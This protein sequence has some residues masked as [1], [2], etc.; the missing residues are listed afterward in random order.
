MTQVYRLCCSAYRASPSENMLH[1]QLLIHVSSPSTTNNEGGGWVATGPIGWASGIT[2]SSVVESDNSTKRPVNRALVA[3]DSLWLQTGDRLYSTDY[4]TTDDSVVDG[5]VGNPWI[6][7]Y[8]FSNVEAGRT[9]RNT[10]IYYVILPSGNAHNKYIIG[11]YNAPGLSSTTWVGWRY[12]IDT[13]TV[14]TNSFNLGFTS[15]ASQGAV[16]AETLHNNQLYFIGATD[17]GIGY[18]NPA[19]MNLGRFLWPTGDIW[20]PHDFCA[21]KGKLYCANRGEN[22]AGG[23]S[24]IYIWE[25][26]G[27]TPTLALN[28]ANHGYGASSVGSEPFEGRNILF[29][30]RSNL[31][32]GAMINLDGTSA[33]RFMR[34]GITSGNLQFLDSHPSLFSANSTVRSNFFTEQNSYPD[35]DGDGTSN[36]QLMTLMLDQAG[37]TGTLR[38]QWA[39][40]GPSNSIFLEESTT[41]NILHTLRET[42][43]SHCK[44]GGGER[45][46]NP[47]YGGPRADITSY[48]SVSGM[49]RISYTIYNNPYDFPAG[50]PCS[51]QVKWNTEGHMPFKRGTLRNPS[52]GTLKENNTVVVL[53]ALSGV[54]NTIDWVLSSDGVSANPI[55]NLLISSTGVA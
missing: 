36:G 37:T 20:G 9:G 30:D 50:T 33:Y 44:N 43:R 3:G 32:L 8:T 6:L 47:F 53:P 18:F 13:K 52:T 15:S 10:G 22:G 1:S 40:Q 16:V 14:E 26:K 2:F 24:G 27:P 11:A 31:F 4:V 49:L 39:W 34:M 54:T 38:Q 21:F 12:N 29:T 17:G 48:T 19:S 51:I 45:I 25:V 28:L 23:G 55:I 5:F 35:L 46:W 7:R 41:G 42:A